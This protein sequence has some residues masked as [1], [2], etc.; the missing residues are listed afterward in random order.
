MG[1]NLSED[2]RARHDLIEKHIYLI[3]LLAR[4]YASHG[5]DVEELTSA[6]AIGLVKAGNTFDPGKHVKFA[7][8]ATRCMENELAMQL[9]RIRRRQRTVSLYEVVRRDAD[10]RRLRLEEVLGTEADAVAS[11]LEA[12][13][14][15]LALQRALDSLGELERRVIAY[16][17]GLNGRPRL[18]QSQLA[19]R[20]GLSQSG[21]SRLERRILLRLRAALERA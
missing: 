17:Y 16:R 13:D 8:Y 11:E 19:Q 14:E 9:R 5:C 18:T 2:I 12:R 10:G 6:G 7:T 15:R 3:S 1:Q 21:M 20:L 4:K